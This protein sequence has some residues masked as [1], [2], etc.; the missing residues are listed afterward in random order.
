MSRRARSINTTN[1]NGLSPFARPILLGHACRLVFVLIG[2]VEVKKRLYVC[3][4]C[5]ASLALH[6][7]QLLSL[8]VTPASLRQKSVEGEN[9]L[10]VRSASVRETPLQCF[11]VRRARQH[12]FEERR[13]FDAQKAAHALICAGGIL[14]RRQ[15]ALGAQAHLVQHAPE[16]NEPA[17]LFGGMSE[18]RNPHGGGGPMAK[19]DFKPSVPH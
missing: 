2:F 13:I 5:K 16:E 6:L 9:L 1:V 7:L 8:V 3:P 12:A 15:L 18:A 14:V 4:A 17:H 19:R 11:L 10:L